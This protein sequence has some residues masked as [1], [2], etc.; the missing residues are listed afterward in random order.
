MG[1]NYRSRALLLMYVV[2]IGAAHPSIAQTKSPKAVVEDFWKMDT[3]GGRLTD[4]GWRAADSFFVRPIQPPKNKIICVIGSS[5]SVGYVRVNG[6]AAE[7]IVN[8][9]GTAW[10]IDP[11][12]RL[13]V[14][15]DQVK[16]FWMYKLKLTHKH[17]EFA[18]DHRTLTEV[19][20]PAEW[21]LER[22]DNY[23]Y[24][25]RDT[26]I[27]YLTDVQ[28]NTTDSAMKKNA[29]HTLATMKRQHY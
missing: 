20:G 16:V 9:A 8:T 25:A 11:M 28:R 3:E 19:S 2:A 21:R 1:S 13:G 18:S 22:E 26:A 15:S 4:A 23:V 6:N 24:L 5:Y 10:K 14:C 12:M 27:R 17:W 7:V 29:E